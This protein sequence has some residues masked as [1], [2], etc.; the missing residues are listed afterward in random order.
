MSI[1]HLADALNTIKTH[2][3]AGKRE[4]VVN[5]SKLVL[6]MLK[7]LKDHS[8][9][10]DFK[11]V[12]DKRGGFFFVDLAGRINNCGVIKPRFPVKRDEWATTEQ[13]YIPGVGIGLLIVSTSN[14]IMTN[15][16]AEK[17]QIGG[18][19]LAYVY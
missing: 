14:G 13:Q 12:D 2:E 4:C 6:N 5:A 15:A 7:V 11:F 3:I 16:D 17:K 9:L 8:Y 18:R 10:K 1:D 19:L